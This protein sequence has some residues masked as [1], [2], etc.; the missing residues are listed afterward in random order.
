MSS[1][2]EASGARFKVA[3]MTCGHCESTIRKALGETMPGAVVT[4]DLASHEV[5]VAG[6]A[7][8]A[9]KTIRDAGYEPQRLGS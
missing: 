1:N 9:E 5:T 3:D 2:P 6:D 7:G 4:I 8:L